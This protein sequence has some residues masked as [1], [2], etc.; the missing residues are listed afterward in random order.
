MKNKG[1]NIFCI[2]KLKLKRKLFS[3]ILNEKEVSKTIKNICNFNEI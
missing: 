1:Y 3:I 2:D